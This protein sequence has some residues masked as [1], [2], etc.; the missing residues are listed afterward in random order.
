M[1]NAWNQWVIGYNPQRQLELMSRL[2]MKS[3]DWRTMSMALA[4]CSSLILAFVAVGTLYRRTKESPERQAWDD[5]CRALERHGVHRSQWEGPFA[6]AERV[7]REH[8]ELSDVTHEAANRYASLHYG[9]VNNPE[10]LQA[11]KHCTRR[12]ASRRRE[13]H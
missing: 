9:E 6:L 5:F 13:L 1:N 11:L 4:A 2:G 3:P 12:L 10:N 8:P 7:S